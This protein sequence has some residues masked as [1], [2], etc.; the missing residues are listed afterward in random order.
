MFIRYLQLF[1]FRNYKQLNIELNKN[2][3]VFIGDNA[4]GKTNILESIYYC[5]IGK[6]HRT[7]RDRELVKWNE[8]NSYI[9]LYVEKERLDKKIEIIIVKD[10]KK[11]ININSRKI[12]KISELIGNLNVV[13]F[14]PEDLKIVKESATFRR[15]FLDIELCKL[16]GSY[17]Y[18]LVQYNKVLNERNVLLKN[19]KEEN[20][21][22]IGI[23]DSQLAQFGSYIIKQRK[24]Y[25][26]KLNDKGKII[27]NEITNGSEEI[28]FNYL[29]SVKNIDG[30]E[31]ELLQILTKNRKKDRERGNTNFGPHRD[32]FEIYI[33]NIDSR[34][35]G[36]QGQQRTSV[37]SIKFASLE[38]IKENIGEYPVLLLDDVLSELDE[39]R[40][41]YI[42]NSIKN[43]QTIITSTGINDIKE[44]MNE[45]AI[46]FNVKN[47]QI[48]DQW[49]I[50]KEKKL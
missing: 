26:K 20:N 32:D 16:D 6:S 31:N 1:N 49:T 29:T 11:A 22:I 28:R 42:L 24:K 40:Q 46:I 12:N 41:K 50:E 25:I 5:S 8:E 33:N 21:D 18:N 10:G 13:M 35:Y 39:K 44:Y 38:I 45:D 7:N 14:S 36:S 17:Y 3:N 48:I 37:L 23:Y 9:K 19:W 27:H 15:K 2:I 30:E 43:I 4:Q 34:S 47:G